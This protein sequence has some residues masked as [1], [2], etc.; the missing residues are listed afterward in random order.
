MGA[1]TVLRAL[2]SHE[3]IFGLLMGSNTEKEGH[4]NLTGEADTQTE[5]CCHLETSRAACCSQPWR[6]WTHT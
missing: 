1:T 2:E 4:Q 5:T 3:F 6:T